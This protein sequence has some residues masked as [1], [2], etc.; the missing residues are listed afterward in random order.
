M[1]RQGLIPKGHFERIELYTN[2]YAEGKD[3]FTGK[4]LLSIEYEQR[5]ETEKRKA[6]AAIHGFT[7]KR[8]NNEVSS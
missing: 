1:T 6:D 7:N 8:V 3:I 2:R 5:E 4:S